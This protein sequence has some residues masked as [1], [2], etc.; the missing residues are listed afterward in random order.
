MNDLSHPNVVQL[1]GVS[2]QFSTDNPEAFYFG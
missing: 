1:V 2:A